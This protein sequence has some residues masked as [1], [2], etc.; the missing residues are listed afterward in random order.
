[1]STSSNMQPAYW[2]EVAAGNFRKVMWPW[3]GFTAAAVSICFLPMAFAN[4]ASDILKIWILVMLL[5]AMAGPAV[6][7]GLVAPAKAMTP[8]QPVAGATS[9]KSTWWLHSTILVL[10]FGLPIFIAGFVLTPIQAL[11]GGQ[12]SVFPW[13]A[14]IFLMQMAYCYMT[15]GAL[16][17]VLV[18]RRIFAWAIVAITP[19]LLALVTVAVAKLFGV[20]VWSGA[21]DGRPYVPSLYFWITIAAGIPAYAAARYLWLRREARD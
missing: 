18:R 9:E 11:F 7:V 10:L 1:M 3:L 4:P 14:L 8:V 6:V 12:N 2:P 21:G 13:V 5:A 16:T 17:S 15:I 19:F 20:R